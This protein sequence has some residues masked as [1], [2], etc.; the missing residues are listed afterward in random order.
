MGKTPKQKQRD[1]AARLHRLGL[2]KELAKRVA[3]NATNV[4]G[5]LPSSAR[6]TIDE[7]R[8]RAA[9]VGGGVVESTK[10]EDR[11]GEGAAPEGQAKAAKQRP[12]RKAASRKLKKKA[13]KLR[14]KLVKK[15][16]KAAKAGK[17]KKSAKGKQAKK[18][19]KDK[20]SAKGKQ[21]RKAA[22]AKKSASR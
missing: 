2:R 3:A 9:D 16:A 11:V 21:A 19:G 5:Q 6:R 4:R 14:K 7:L 17:G 15:A 18:A 13:K 22:K 12:D 8:L 1:L 10:A 20:K